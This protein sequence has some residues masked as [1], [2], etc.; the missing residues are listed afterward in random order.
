MKPSEKTPGM[1]KLLTDMFG[2]DLRPYIEA[3]K[4]VPQPYG[5]GGPAGV[6]RDEGSIAEYKISGMCQHC[7][8]RTFGKSED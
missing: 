6:F 5:C 7:Q 1:E 8:D 4:C 2:F 3:D